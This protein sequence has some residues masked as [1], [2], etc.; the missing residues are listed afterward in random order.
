MC[1][2]GECFESAFLYC[3][4]RLSRYR[5]CYLNLAAPSLA[6]RL[7]TCGDQPGSSATTTE[8]RVA[9]SPLYTMI[10]ISIAVGER[11]LHGY[12]CAI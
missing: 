3:W 7:I 4:R 2:W 12:V 5:K 11:P 9:K 1:T 8:N 6:A 10:L